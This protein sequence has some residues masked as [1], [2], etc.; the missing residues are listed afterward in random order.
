MKVCKIKGKS[1][2]NKVCTEKDFIREN[3]KK[4]EIDEEYFLLEKQKKLLFNNFQQVE[5][6]IK[7]LFI[8][9]L[10]KKIKSYKSQD[11]KKERYDELN[12]VNIDNVIELLKNSDLKCYY[13][14]EE[15]YILYKNIREN[16]QW[17]LDRVDNDLG[18]INDNLVISCLKCN[19]KRRKQNDIAF[20][21]T[22]QL[23]IKKIS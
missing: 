1:N 14:K 20:L 3:V 13:C 8:D 11:L 21:F 4:W 6:K 23:D 12:F 10:N 7:K 17:T 18:H 2:I 5:D 9:E 19:L 16:L 15:V 22:R